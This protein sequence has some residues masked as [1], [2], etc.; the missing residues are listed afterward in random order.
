MAFIN[1]LYTSFIITNLF[2]CFPQMFAMTHF[3]T[4]PMIIHDPFIKSLK[5]LDLFDFFLIFNCN[6][7]IWAF[8]LINGWLDYAPKSKEA[9]IFVNRISYFPIHQPQM[10][11]LTIR[12]LLLDLKIKLGW[13][14]E[15]LSLWKSLFC[16]IFEQSSPI[17]MTNFEIR[18]IVLN[19]LKI[20]LE[21]IERSVRF[22]CCDCCGRLS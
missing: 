20:W 10:P 5:I 15:I 18:Y 9:L 2:Q 11:I 17:G 4:C 8:N 12:N 14:L 19:W 16:L 6:L 22:C 13:L 7:A 21:I 3:A 1:F